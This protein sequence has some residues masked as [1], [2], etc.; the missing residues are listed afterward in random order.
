MSTA[1]QAPQPKRSTTLQ[2]FFAAALG[3][4]AAVLVIIFLSQADDDNPPSNVPLMAVVVAAQPI[5]AGETIT[6]S[7][8]DTSQVP[9]AAAATD[10][11]GERALVEGKVARYPIAEGEQ[12][13]GGRLVDPPQVQA[14]SFQIPEGM[15]G[16][17]IPV[18]VNDTPAA[19]LAPGDFV[20]VIVSVEV[21]ALV[22]SVSSELLPTPVAGEGNEDLKGAATILQ[23]V[24]VLS[25]AR[26]YVDTGVVYEASTRGEP[27]A[28]DEAVAFVT[29]AV[30]PEDA[31]LLWL[32]QDKGRLT[33]VLR[34]FADDRILPLRPRIEPLVLEP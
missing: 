27:P 13:T 3:L 18:S 12:I 9:E 24:Q 17:T 2:L 8:L 25:V 30:S 23:N 5:A 1:S 11:F 14:L 15:R 33:L 26:N 22:G 6:G 34:A 19:L 31:Q 29:L 4:I 21:L 28:D 20:D 7:K 10:G 16:M 32:S